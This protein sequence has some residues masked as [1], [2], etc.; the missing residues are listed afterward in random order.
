MTTSEI[1]NYRLLNQQIAATNFKQPREIVSWMVAM[2]AQEYAMAKWSIGLRLQEI[3]D[4]DVE[5]AFNDGTILRTHVMRPTWHFVTPA[6]IRWLIKLTAPRVHASNAFMRRKMELDSKIFKR[7][8]DTLVKE[9]RDGN[10]LTR[11]TLKSALERAK[12]FGD[13]VRISYLMMQA[14]LDGIICSGPRQGKQFTYA[15]MDERVPPTKII[16]RE[17]AL[18][19]FTARYFTSRGPATV[20]DFVTWSGLTMK[21]AK[22]GVAALDRR[23][24]KEIIE[25]KEYIL[26]PATSSPDK[27]F[28]TTFLMPDYDEYG[29]SYKDRS[30]IFSSEN[31][32]AISRKNPVFNRM[33]ILNGRI[34]GTWQRKIKGDKMMVETVPFTSLSKKKNQQVSQAIK[35][36]RRFAGNTYE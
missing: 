5:A 9:L 15:L 29:M 34:A 32:H 3:K 13:G 4:A 21:D 28:Q 7:S 8:N 11:V 33:I 14:E 25:G 1:I 23:F 20:Q 31:I 26:L 30:A 17:E 35:R 12:I 24:V 19:K 2:Q 36:F 6:D 16:D 27:K 18:Y 22:D 10:Q